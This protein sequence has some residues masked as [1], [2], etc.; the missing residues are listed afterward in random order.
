MI[1]S[2]KMPVQHPP[3]L[4]ALNKQIGLNSPAFIRRPN[5]CNEFGNSTYLTNVDL[6]ND[7]Q[8]AKF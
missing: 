4:T 8:V 6:R 2:T 7:V 5:Y 3:Y 1:R